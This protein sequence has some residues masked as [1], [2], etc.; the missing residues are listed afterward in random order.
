MQDALRK[1]ISLITLKI[2]L[3]MP[4]CFDCW[5]HS[6]RS[7]CHALA[8]RLFCPLSSGSKQPSA[9]VIE[10]RIKDDVVVRVPRYGFLRGPMLGDPISRPIEPH[11]IKHHKP[12][13]EILDF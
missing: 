12:C 5:S 8:S 13:S 7:D 3:I 10:T 9:V 4:S 2:I 11:M 1:L 6:H